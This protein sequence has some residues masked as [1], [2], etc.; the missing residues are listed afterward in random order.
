MYNTKTITNIS[1]VGLGKLGLYI[2]AVLADRDFNLKAIELDTAKGFLS[3]QAACKERCDTASGV[4]Y[5][6]KEKSL[7]I[8]GSE[9]SHV[10]KL[11]LHIATLDIIFDR[12]GNVLYGY[13][14]LPPYSNVWA[15]IGGR[16]L[17]GEGL[18]DT[19][20]RISSECDLRIS[21]PRHSGLEQISS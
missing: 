11:R 9:R 14:R 8:S 4:D 1:V 16:I 19:I 2:A 13:R 17:F 21:L 5:S 3:C 18:L 10:T 15:F 6:R 12:D 7:L 20:R